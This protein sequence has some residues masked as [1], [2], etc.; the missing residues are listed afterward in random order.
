MGEKF[1][2]S[3]KDQRCDAFRR[4]ISTTSHL[5]VLAWRMAFSGHRLDSR[6]AGLDWMVCVM[7]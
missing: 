6:R 1:A 7:E 2:T 3:E 5:D 4:L